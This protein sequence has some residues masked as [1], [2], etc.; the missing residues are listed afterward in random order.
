MDSIVKRKSNNYNEENEIWE[1]GSMDFCQ[2]DKSVS[3]L[4]ICLKV[5]VYI[6]FH[7]WS[8]ILTMFTLVVVQYFC[9]KYIADNIRT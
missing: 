9:V 6:K 1:I 5:C 2:K 4:E 3:L 7:Q 8:V